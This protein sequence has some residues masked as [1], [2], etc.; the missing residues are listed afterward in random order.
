MLSAKRKFGDHV[1]GRR[2]RARKEEESDVEVESSDAPSEEDVGASE[3][4][5]S[6]E[7]QDSEDDSEEEEVWSTPLLVLPGT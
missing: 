2:V 5:G 3:D 1:L 6:E 7:E 4:K